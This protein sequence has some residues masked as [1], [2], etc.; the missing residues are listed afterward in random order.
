MMY[1]ET[2]AL[3]EDADKPAY[4]RSLTSLLCPLEEVLDS[5]L[6][7]ERPVKIY[8]IARMYRLIQVLSELTIHNV[9][10][11]TFWPISTTVNTLVTH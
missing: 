5:W 9:H 2:Y 1:L 7:T 10:S 4:L 3:I 6:S 11:L 8:Q